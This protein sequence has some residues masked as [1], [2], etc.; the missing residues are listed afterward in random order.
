MIRGNLLSGIA[1]ILISSIIISCDGNIGNN[2]T[3]TIISEIIPSVIPNNNFEFHVSYGSCLIDSYNSKTGIY[4]MD[5]GPKK[6]KQTAIIQLSIE[7]KVKIFTEMSNIGIFH[8]PKVIILP[9]STNGMVGRSSSTDHYY[10]YVIDGSNKNEINWTNDIFDPMSKE[11]AQFI[12]LMNDIRK[13][14]EDQPEVKALPSRWIGC[15]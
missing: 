10:L 7:E 3:A 11:G 15:I 9:T 1:I 13:V 5:M 4:T 2:T 12:K 6:E 14:I 8:Y